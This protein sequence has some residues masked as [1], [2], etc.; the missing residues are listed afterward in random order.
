MKF[1]V[2]TKSRAWAL[3]FVIFLIPSAVPSLTTYRGNISFYILAAFTSVISIYYFALYYWRRWRLDGTS[4]EKPPLGLDAAL[5]NSATTILVEE[6]EEGNAGTDQQMEQPMQKTRSYFLDNV[7]WCL[8]TN[9]L[10]FHLWQAFGGSIGLRL[11]PGITMGVGGYNDFHSALYWWFGMP[12]QTYFMALFFFISAYF[13]PRSLQKKGRVV[14]IKERAQR[15]WTGA[16]VVTFIF[17][18]LASFWAWSV[19]GSTE[20][21][22]YNDTLDYNYS[23]RAGNSW[24]LWWLLL[25]N[26]WYVFVVTN[27]DGEV[28]EGFSL[29]LSKYFK[30]IPNSPW[31][32]W[33]VGIFVCGLL[34]LISNWFLFATW[35]T[36]T[37]P[38]GGFAS[39][40]I[41]V[42]TFVSYLLLFY[43][44]LLAGENTWFA[45]EKPAIRQSLGM[46]VWLFRIIVFVEYILF[47]LGMSFQEGIQSVIGLRVY[48][49]IM[50]IIA[51]LMTLDISLAMLELFQSHFDYTNTIL[52]WLAKGAYGAFLLENLFIWTAPAAIFAYTY[53]GPLEWKDNASGA[54]SYTPIPVQTLVVAYVYSAAFW[55]PFCWVL[56]SILGRLP[57]LK[58][59][60]H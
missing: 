24:F 16:M 58:K 34:Q 48:W 47:G 1:V 53:N 8:I 20:D 14:F 33:L 25:F 22:S 30:T 51:G 10:L 54:A 44:G 4:D 3:G 59:M 38:M 29:P 5:L 26:F 39:M 6:V 12:S 52:T 49:V 46:N 35:D 15:V 23:L 27:T 31:V 55:I 41:N 42:G 40:P 37:E 50:Y 7:K 18:P 9:V 56:S 21:H 11:V 43:I 60:L 28:P 17:S 36:P 45:P 57:V 2:L 32:R 13:L 19:S